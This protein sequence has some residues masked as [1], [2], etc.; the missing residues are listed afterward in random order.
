V[1][2]S[3]EQ[4]AADVLTATVGICGTSL[5]AVIASIHA[6]LLKHASKMDVHR[7]GA[8]WLPVAWLLCVALPSAALRRVFPVKQVRLKTA[9]IHV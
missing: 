4:G 7:V 9:C 1:A 2:L 8:F 3:I 6:A 5:L